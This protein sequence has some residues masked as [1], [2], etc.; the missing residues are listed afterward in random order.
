VLKETG[1]GRDGLEIEITENLLIGDAGNIVEVLD[2]LHD[3][4][5][6]ITLDDFG[7]GYSS[8]S[9]LRRYPIDTIKI[10]GTFVADIAD[11]P[12]DAEIIHTIINMGKTLNRTVVAEGVESEK[13]VELLRRYQ[14]DEIQGYYLCKPL[15]AAELTRFLKNRMRTRETV[16]R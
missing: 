11:N 6:Y 14:C 10:D 7:T 9:H 1:V 8:L 16:S 4:G 2:R 3:L 13:Q 15:P 5:V 12:A